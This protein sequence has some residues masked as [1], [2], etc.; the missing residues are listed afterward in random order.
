MTDITFSPEDIRALAARLDHV[1]A[2]FDERERALL[3][4]IIGL[5]QEALST[6]AEGE[7]TGF[8]VGQPGM[9]GLTVTKPTGGS[10]PT[11]SEALSS[12]TRKEVATFVVRAFFL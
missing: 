10:F 4:T 8:G 5:A 3:V 7:V 12:L 9:T 11:P 1:T 2:E 6:Q